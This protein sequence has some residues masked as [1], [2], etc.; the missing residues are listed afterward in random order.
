MPLNHERAA[1]TPDKCSDGPGYMPRAAKDTKIGVP[2]V[3][4]A[5]RKKS[6]EPERIRFAA[7]LPECPVISQ[8]PGN[9]WRG[10]EEDSGAPTRI[11]IRRSARTR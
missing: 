3:P 8:A 10:A 9:P 11:D 5:G 4:S 2:D 6:G 1:L 7:S